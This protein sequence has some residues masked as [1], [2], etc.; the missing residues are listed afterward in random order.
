MKQ[1]KKWPEYGHFLYK[2]KY[3]RENIIFYDIL[4]RKIDFGPF[5]KNYSQT[6][7]M[8]RAQRLQYIG[9]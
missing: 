5:L 9:E 7:Y 2:S 3:K 6:S 4:L 8:I 1:N